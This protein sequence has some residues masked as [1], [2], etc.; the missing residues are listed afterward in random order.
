MAHFEYVPMPGGDAAVREPWRMAAT[1]LYRAFGED[2]MKLK[3]EFVRRIDPK[4]WRIIKRMILGAVN[5]PLTSSAGRLFDAAAS[6][7]LSSMRPVREA[8]LPVA[9]EEIADPGVFD[10]YLFNIKAAGGAIVFGYGKI[11]KG[12]VGDLSRGV[13]ESMVSARFHNTIAKI[14]AEA[15]ARLGKSCGI[16]QA[17]LSGG[18]FHNVY[19]AARAVRA[20]ERKGFRVYTHSIL[21]P[22]DSCIPLGQIAIAAARGICA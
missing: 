20:L 7:T 9:L 3:I 5:S 11:F 13:D 17:V 22:G 16:R 12:I 4:K 15:A 8:E 1:H 18:V 19:L 21:S 14:M 2:F 10:S 6:V